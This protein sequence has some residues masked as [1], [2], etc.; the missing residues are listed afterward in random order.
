MENICSISLL[1]TH[2]A[3]IECKMADLISMGYHNIVDI[4]ARSEAQYLAQAATFEVDTRPDVCDDA[5]P[6][7]SSW[8]FVGGLPELRGL[9]EK[10]SNCQ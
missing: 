1:V 2:L 6:V 4:S 9:K 8:V 5:G 7:P 3:V 10:I